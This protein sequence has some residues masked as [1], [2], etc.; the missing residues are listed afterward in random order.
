[1]THQFDNASAYPI[2]SSLS[3]LLL[4]FALLI[5][6][7]GLPGDGFSAIAS[8]SFRKSLRKFFWRECRNRAQHCLI[9]SVDGIDRSP[10]SFQLKKPVDWFECVL[11]F[12]EFLPVITFQLSKYKCYYLFQ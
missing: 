2:E 1:M 6:L 9:P 4:A 5:A 11:D 8:S 12:C 7:V 10:C 3:R